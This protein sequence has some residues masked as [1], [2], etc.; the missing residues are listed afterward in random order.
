MKKKE[1]LT[2]G[3]T[4]TT[5]FGTPAS[6]DKS[7]MSELSELSDTSG[8]SEMS[9]NYDED[10]PKKPSKWMMFLYILA[11]IGDLLTFLCLFPFALLGLSKHPGV[12]YFV[13]RDMMRGK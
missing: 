1:E 3:T 10:Q 6:S 13:F 5:V 7:D 8:G 9:D 11:A 2:R 12:G 4:P